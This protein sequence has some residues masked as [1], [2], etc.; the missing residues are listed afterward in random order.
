MGEIK[1]LKKVN[2]RIKRNKLF[3]PAKRLNR[4]RLSR[5]KTR[6]TGLDELKF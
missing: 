1:E 4:R 6:Q 5:L 3:K 2:L